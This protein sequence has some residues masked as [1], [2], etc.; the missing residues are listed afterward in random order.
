MAGENRNG[1]AD[2][3]FGDGAQR[4]RLAMGELEEL[5][6]KTGAGPF[7][8]AQRLMTG[9]WL[10]A[11]VRETIRLGLIGG[12]LHPLQAL[13]LVRRYVDERPHWL[14]NAAIAQI[15]LSAALAGAPEEEPGK[16]GAPEATNEA[17][18]FPTAASP[19]A[20]ST[21]QQVPAESGSATSDE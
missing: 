12:G 2:L 20:H 6:E 15:V 8:V 21:E 17:S 10:V 18:S 13:G 14:A 19:S 16:E 5:Q 11:D 3:D 1:V 4:F 9:D 7:K